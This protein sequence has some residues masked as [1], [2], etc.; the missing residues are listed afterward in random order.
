[1]LA[2]V[3]GVNLANA[4]IE[5]PEDIAEVDAVVP[6]PT[7]PAD[8]SQPDQTLA[9]ID[10]GPI[11][12]G[13]VIDVGAGFTIQPPAG[14][15]VISQEDDVV[16]LQKGATILVV[17]GIPTAD[18]P[19]DLATWY[20]DAWFADGS[21]TG[22]EPVSRAVGDGLPGAE[23]DYTGIF[24][25]TQIDGR[26]VTASSAGSGLLVNALAPTGELGTSD[27]LE[28]ILASVRLGGG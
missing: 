5:P 26:I 12:Q 21:Y 23:L 11:A 19:E 27:D 4:S 13:D 20:R 14:W 25:G 9:P 28:A 16:V 6:E 17:A 18:T 2:L 22:G 7:L 3:I 8:P 1:M 24:Q 15:S 10:P